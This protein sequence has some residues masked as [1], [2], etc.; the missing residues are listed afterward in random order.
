MRAHARTIH[1]T[2]KTFAGAQ[3]ILFRQKMAPK[4]GEIH[5]CLGRPEIPFLDL[6][7]YLRFVFFFFL[8]LADSGMQRRNRTGFE[9]K[10]RVQHTSGSAVRPGFT[11]LKTLRDLC[12]SGP[13]LNQRKRDKHAVINLNP[14][15]TLNECALKSIRRKRNGKNVKHDVGGET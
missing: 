12:P 8:F 11:E 2:Q 13:K 6:V 9:W 5:L 1:S 15:S 14:K 10:T 4:S 7:P 3:V